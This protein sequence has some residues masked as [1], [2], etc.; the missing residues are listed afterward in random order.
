MLK[1]S[2]SKPF[3]LILNNFNGFK[4][5][6]YLVDGKKKHS[7][8]FSYFS[9]SKHVEHYKSKNHHGLT[10]IMVYY[11]GTYITAG[12]ANSKQTLI[13]CRKLLR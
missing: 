11:V 4:K 10:G 5:T 8:W 13:G 9:K 7:S 6:K 3:I 1:L 12:D 2:G